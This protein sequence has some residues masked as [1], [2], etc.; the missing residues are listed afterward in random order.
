MTTSIFKELKET[1]YKELKKRIKA[2]FARQSTS[3]RK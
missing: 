1:I 3:V 2:T